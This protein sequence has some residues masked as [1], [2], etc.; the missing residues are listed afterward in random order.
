MRTTLIL[1]AAL[2]GIFAIGCIAIAYI[3]ADEVIADAHRQRPVRL[4][5]T[6]LSSEQRA[7]LLAVEDPAFD[8]HH[9]VDLWTPGA[10]LTTMTQGLVKFLYFDRFRPGLAKIPQTF[11]AIG[12]DAAVSK[13]EQ[14][15][16]VLNHTY[17]GT[18]EGRA[19]HGYADAAETYMGRPL[20]DLSRREF[21][22]L[23]ATAIAPNQLNPLKAPGANLQRTMRIER[24]LAG[25]C[26]PKGVRD[27]YYED[28]KTSDL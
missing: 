26:A 6:A 16:L 4:P 12:F 7:I 9:G 19:I 21:I 27:V 20:P 3:R 14:L 23:V 5:V 10:G 15:E 18:V 25:A 17:L 1:L 11:F 2:L 8:R 22:Q 28:C 24:L 13:S